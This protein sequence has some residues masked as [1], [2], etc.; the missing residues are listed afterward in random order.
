MHYSRITLGVDFSSN[1]LSTVS[2]GDDFC[3]Y[4]EVAGGPNGAQVNGSVDVSTAMG[5]VRVDDSTTP[6][7]E[8]FPLTITGNFDVNGGANQTIT[9][10]SSMRGTFAGDAGVGGQATNLRFLA[11]DGTTN[12]SSSGDIP[13]RIITELQ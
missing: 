4:D 6:S 3:F 8:D 11:G 5:D 9:G 12:F 13:T 7:V 2:G 1:A 10:A